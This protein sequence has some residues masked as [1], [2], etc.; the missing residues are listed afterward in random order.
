MPQRYWPSIQVSL[1]VSS[2]LSG[3]T[4]LT[5]HYCATA[6]LD[7]LTGPP[8]YRAEAEAASAASDKGEDA[9]EDASVEDKLS[10]STS[11]TSTDGR[12]S[13]KENRLVPP[14]KGKGD[15]AVAAADGPAGE[16]RV[17]PSKKRARKAPPSSLEVVPPSNQGAWTNAE[18]KQVGSCF[19]S[20]SLPAE[21]SPFL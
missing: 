3:G 1:V 11:T 21:S 10:G 16:E 8:A 12:I 17:A 13:N 4:K 19:G 20:T 7:A 2:R 9:G 14:A 18:K 15:G 5:L 6:T